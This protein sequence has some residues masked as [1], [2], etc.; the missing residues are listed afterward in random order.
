MA[1]SELEGLSG[2]DG[3]DGC[4]VCGS[5][6]VLEC[7]GISLGSL[8]SFLTRRISSRVRL[9]DFFSHCPQHAVRPD[10]PA[11][12]NEGQISSSR[13]AIVRGRGTPFDHAP[14]RTPQR[15]TKA[16]PATTPP[17]HT[18]R[19]SRCNASA[20]YPQA[21]ALAGAKDNPPGAPPLADASW[22]EA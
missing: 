19:L 21:C 22:F 18:S 16:A 1:G 12:R 17:I 11:L 2:M 7:L 14:P 13:G 8:V 6:V 9:V 3:V 10:R 20:Q 5:A 4:R 15:G